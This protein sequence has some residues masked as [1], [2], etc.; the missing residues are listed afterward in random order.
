MVA[1][2]D[3]YTFSDIEKRLKTPIAVDLTEGLTVSQVFGEMDDWKVE[4]GGMLFFLNPINRCWLLFDN[5][6]NDWRDT[7]RFAGELLKDSSENPEKDT[8]PEEQISNDCHSKA[9][10]TQQGEGKEGEY[11]CLS[12]Q[13]LIGNGRNCDIKLLDSPKGVHLA[14]I[15]EHS[16][17]YSILRLDENYHVTVNGKLV[18][19]SG[20]L[21]NEG[22]IVNINN[23]ILKFCLPVSS[24][25]SV[26][27][28]VSIFR[29][30]S[31]RAE[32]DEK[33]KFCTACGTP[34]PQA[35]KSCGN[36]DM[37]TCPHCSEKVEQQQKFCTSCGERLKNGPEGS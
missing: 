18:G 25:K 19:G 1:S 26:S 33:M 17:G 12:P 22:D 13:T 32:F 9:M 27:T 10:L 31:C 2:T 35:V 11:Y 6:H 7:G 15:L 4:A 8:K 30:K 20:A 37:N 28:P 3:H 24:Q 36:I 23:T 29:C 21:I 14:L 34:D 5:I 16:G